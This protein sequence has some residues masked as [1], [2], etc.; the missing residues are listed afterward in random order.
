MQAIPTSLCISGASKLYI[1]ELH[2]VSP[3]MSSKMSL[4]VTN[5]VTNTPEEMCAKDGRENGRDS[6]IDC[7]NG[8]KQRIYI[9]EM[10]AVRK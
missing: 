3:K 8:K 2:I 10:A 9:A 6:D 5:N 1:A 4:I 7:V